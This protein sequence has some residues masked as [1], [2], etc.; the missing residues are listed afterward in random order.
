MSTLLNVFSRT[1]NPDKLIK[2]SLANLDVL[3]APPTE[4]KAEEAGEDIIEKLGTMKGILYGDADNDPDPT[5][6]T[7]LITKLI[8]EPL[9]PSLLEHLEVIPFEARKTTSL[10]FSNLLR[11]DEGFVQFLTTRPDLLHLILLGHQQEA[12]ALHCGSM[13]QE[14]IK[15]E[16]LWQALSEDGL[17]WE[18]FSTFPQNPNFDLSIDAFNSLRDFLLRHKQAVSAFLLDNYDAFVDCFQRLLESDNYVIQRQSVRLLG[19]V[20]LDRSNYEVML[21]FINSQQNLQKVMALLLSP[22]PAIQFEAFQ[23]FKVFVVN[24]NKAQPISMVLYWNGNKLKEF[25]SNFQAEKDDEDAMFREEKEAVLQAVE[26]VVE[27]CKQ[28][29]SFPVPP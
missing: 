25:L 13:L 19:E 29:P 23:L 3:M 11:N 6:V 4:Q 17:I 18:L 7:T 22:S 14:L 21:R 12:T 16:V 5:R 2:Q 28:D 24:P 10:I 20:L 8:E 9:L 27:A 15:Y 26:S 1:K